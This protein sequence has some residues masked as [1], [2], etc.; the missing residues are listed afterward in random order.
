MTLSVGRIR[1]GSYKEL[2]DA[3][4]QLLRDYL[5]ANVLADRINAEKRR[6]WMG[7]RS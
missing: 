2:S 1:C 4:P 5:S 3:A 7:S 6:R